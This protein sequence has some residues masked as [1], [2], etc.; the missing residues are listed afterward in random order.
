[1]KM[2]VLDIQKKTGKVLK[3]FKKKGKIYRESEK[4]K[5]KSVKLKKG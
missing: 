3:K 1:M 5:E 4:F 2:I